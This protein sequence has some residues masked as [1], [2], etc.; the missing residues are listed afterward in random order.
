MSKHQALDPCEMLLDL[1][2]G[3]YADD[4]VIAAVAWLDL[5]SWLSG[6]PSTKEEIS[7]SLDLDDRPLD[8]LLTLL[9]ALG[10]VK[11]RDNIFTTTEISEEF[12]VGGRPN[13]LVPFF[14]SQKNRPSC[15]E[16]YEVLK[17]GEPTGWS[18]QEK[19][20]DWESDGR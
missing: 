14:A 2:D 11:R 20:K 3:I 6:H 4:L 1:R 17:T 12:L 15:L 9:A 7:D 19:G 16:L 8:V 18:S 10:L 13:C 5:F